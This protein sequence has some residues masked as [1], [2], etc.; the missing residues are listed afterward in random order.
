M[1][2]SA[3][4]YSRSVVGAHTIVDEEITERSISALEDGVLIG[5]HCSHRLALSG[6]F[7]IKLNLSSSEID[8]L[9]MAGTVELL[10]RRIREL[11]AEIER[12][13]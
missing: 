2:I 3:T 4:G 5:V 13:S 10:E 6:F 12:L 8:R 7:S 11:E 9:R 1:K